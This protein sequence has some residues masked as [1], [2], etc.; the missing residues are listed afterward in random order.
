MEDKFTRYTKLYMIIF[1]LFLAI[2]VMI[3]LLIG[4]FYGFSKIISS[5]PVDFIFQLLILSFPVAVF[6]SAYIIFLKRTKQHPSFIIR[7]CSGVL[8]SVGLI[9]CG[10]FLT[11]DIISFFKVQ[12]NDIS[13][14]HCFSV[15]FMA[16]NIGGLFIIAIVQ[17]FT[18]K[19]EPDWMDRAGGG[20]I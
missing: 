2:P 20:Q 3:A 6:A 8:F 5:A 19:K 10:I 7:I 12:S 13:S 11:M 4:V 15:P 14:Y 1:G 16:G 9:A 18:T 17:A